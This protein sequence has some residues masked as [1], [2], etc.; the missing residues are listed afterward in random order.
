MQKC[1][2]TDTERDAKVEPCQ[3]FCWQCTSVVSKG[4]DSRSLP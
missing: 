3:H 1:P 2:E 4:L